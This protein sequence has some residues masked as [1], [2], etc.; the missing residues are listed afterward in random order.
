M[1]GY[2]LGDTDIL[3]VLDRL[4]FTQLNARSRHYLLSKKGS[5]NNVE[6]R[7]L[8]RD[9]NV[10][11][12]EYKD[13]FGWHNHIDTFLEALIEGLPDLP[14]T[15]NIR[16]DIRLK[17]YVHYAQSMEADGWFVWH[18]IFREGAITWSKEAQEKQ[19]DQLEEQVERGLSGVDCFIFLVS[20]TTP[21]KGSQFWQMI[22]DV[23]KLATQKGVGILYIV[24]GDP[25]RPPFIQEHAPSAPIFNVP[26]QFSEKDLIQVRSYLEQEY[27]RRHSK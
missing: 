1:V 15:S 24:V 5:R 20:G 21:S 9:Q 12:I 26:A 13:H 2:G 16:L 25:L 11:I 6:R 18:Y 19:L 7:R 10:Q 27:R 17:I 22:L 3:T 14:N 4:A 8:L 23:Q